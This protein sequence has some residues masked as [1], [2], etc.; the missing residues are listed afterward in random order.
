MGEKI[1]ALKPI[2]EPSNETNSLA[3]GEQWGNDGVEDTPG[4][5]AFFSGKDSVFQ[6]HSIAHTDAGDAHLGWK[7]L[8]RLPKPQLAGG[9]TR[10]LVG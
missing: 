2:N 8:R 4:R 10:V 5:T 7:R 1:H 6:G 3:W 9:N